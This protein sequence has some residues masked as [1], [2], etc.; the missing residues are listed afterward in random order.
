MRSQASGLGIA[1]FTL[2]CLFALLSLGWIRLLH[3]SGRQVLGR[4]IGLM[5]DAPVR[6]GQA[7]GALTGGV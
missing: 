6:F 5:M 7:C 4:R 2:E 3:W 1:L